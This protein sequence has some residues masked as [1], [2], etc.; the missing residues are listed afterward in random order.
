MTMQQV[1]QILGQPIN[2]HAINVGGVSGTSVRWESRDA[3]IF[4][5]FFN[6]KAKAKSMH[7]A[8]VEFNSGKINTH[9]QNK[10]TQIDLPVPTD[11]IDN[12]NRL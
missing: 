10:H 9:S 11:T 2:V 3:V 1:V 7:E 8:D 5:Q 6:N 12:Q 4:V